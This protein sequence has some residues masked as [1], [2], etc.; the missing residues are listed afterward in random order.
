MPTFHS[1]LGPWVPA[2]TPA[3]TATALNSSVREGGS[4]L[5]GTVT[6]VDACCPSSLKDS[7][8]HPMTIHRVI[9]KYRLCRAVWNKERMCHCCTVVLG[10]HSWQV[11]LSTSPSSLTSIVSVK[12]YNSYSQASGGA[13]TLSPF[14]TLNYV[15]TLEALSHEISRCGNI[16]SDSLLAAGAWPPSERWCCPFSAWKGQRKNWLRLE[17]GTVSVLQ[18]WKPQECGAGGYVNAKCRHK[19]MQARFKLDNIL[20]PN[21]VLNIPSLTMEARYVYIQIPR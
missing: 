3:D 2:L 14:I 16:Q 10:L 19:E 5:P 11:V 18:V 4:F 17:G 1:A 13:F 6:T 20:K 21:N 15:S 7:F 9:W 12:F 8:C